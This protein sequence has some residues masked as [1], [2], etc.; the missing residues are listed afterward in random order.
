[1]EGIQGAPA[2][3][4][5]PSPAP[6]P[7]PAPEGVSPMADLPD[8]TT[9][10]ALTDEPQPSAGGGVVIEIDEPEPEPDDKEAVQEAAEEGVPPADE[11]EGGVPP[12]H[13]G[14]L[15]CEWAGT[16]RTVWPSVT[17]TVH[18]HDGSLDVPAREWAGY[19]SLQ[20]LRISKAEY[21]VGLPKNPRAARPWCFRVSLRVK[22][23][24]MTKLILD[25]GNEQQ[26]DKWIAVLQ[27][28]QP[29]PEPE[30]EAGDAELM[31]TPRAELR[32][33][34]EQAALLQ[35]VGE[36]IKSTIV[37]VEKLMRRNKLCPLDA[38]PMRSIEQ[39]LGRAEGLK[40][41][42][43]DTAADSAVAP[44]QVAPAVV[45]PQPPEPQ[46]EI[47][48]T[49]ILSISE[50]SDRLQE[51]QQVR[52]KGNEAFERGDY[53]AAV[54]FYVSAAESLQILLDLAPQK[55]K[56][57][58][59]QAFTACV[60]QG[61]KAKRAEKQKEQAIADAILAEVLQQ[62]LSELAAKAAD[63]AK[64]AAAKATAKQAAKL[65]AAAIVEQNAQLAGIPN[66]WK[67]QNLD[68][69]PTH[70]NLK[71]GGVTKLIPVLQPE[72][73]PEPEPESEPEPEPEQSEVQ[74][75]RG[76][77]I[78]DAMRRSSTDPGQ[79][80]LANCHVH[81]VER[82]ENMTL[83]QNYQ[84]QKQAI[85]E[86]LKRHP[87]LQLAGRSNLPLLTTC[88]R[89]IDQTLNEFWLWHGT[90]PKTADILALAGFDEKVAAM[91]GLYGAG[92]YF[93]DASSKSQ[94]YATTDSH[95]HYCMLYCRVVMGSP[96]MTNRR[97]KSERRPPDNP[98]FT[99]S[100]IPHDSI[101]AE[102][103]VARGGH[104]LNNEYVVFHPGQAYPEYIVWYTK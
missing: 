68:S 27:S 77:E 1:M 82:V 22:T 28:E 34:F 54:K 86:K 74:D 15:E 89:T 104:Q 20:P 99:Q 41:L 25:A 65:I 69:D 87:P 93:A 3:K 88:D 64:V 51:T 72:P 2:A 50:L 58:I 17:V 98:A 6:E 42:V 67:S 5:A 61:E 32:K 4:D 73:E 31:Q 103:G 56:P 38:E 83:W 39:L 45:E 14:T 46:P 90:T 94:Q 60:A 19:K 10:P 43:N 81:R 36:A 57:S 7:V 53:T 79:H 78:Q 40:Q 8:P 84:R 11:E 97:H 76:E 47:D 30:L 62:E 29:E 59:S 85:R 35:P 24:G 75:C 63:E 21:S 12:L 92:S 96:Y 95:G 80:S 55:Q 18:G 71:T 100:G 13:R 48:E 91:S 23:G 101:M 44:P 33:Q 49:Q 52:N 37:I 9:T 16:F 66:H 70:V 102:T 26:R